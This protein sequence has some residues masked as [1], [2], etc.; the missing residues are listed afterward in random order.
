VLGWAIRSKL[1]SGP[2]PATMEI[3]KDVLG[4]PTH[5]VRH[6]A[7]LSY[8]QINTLVT[9]LLPRGDRDALALLLLI[10]TAT[11]AGAVIGARAKEFDLRA[12]VWTV[13]PGRMKRRGQL[14]ETEF[15][16]PLSD[17]AIAVV[18]RT[19]VKAGL[20]FPSCHWTSLAQV[21]GHEGITVHGFR[22]CFKTWA[23]ERTSPHLI[24][25]G[26][27][28]YTVSI[29]SQLPVPK[30]RVCIIGTHPLSPTCGSTPGRA[31]LK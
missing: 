15:R 11:R 7:A 31:T 30:H 26:I 9:E 13:P 1:R 22:G 16:I 28:A 24:R 12:R 17:N 20:L 23:L 19:G 29:G 5:I 2:N 4:K 25:A 14:K 10:L 18:E 8:K 21:H 6:H 3:I 27:P